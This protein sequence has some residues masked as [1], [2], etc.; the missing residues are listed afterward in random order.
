VPDLSLEFVHFLTELFAVKAYCAVEDTPIEEWFN[1]A[2]IDEIEALELASSMNDPFIKT[3]HLRELSAETR[4][5]IS[6]I[7]RFD[8]VNGKK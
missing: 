2:I 7:S 6:S 1:H 3:H 5:A 4:E 8:E